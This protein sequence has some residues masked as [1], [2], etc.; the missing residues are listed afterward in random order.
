MRTRRPP[1]LAP[2]VSNCHDQANRHIYSVF[3]RNVVSVFHRPTV[4][5][6]YPSHAP[7]ILR[8]SARPSI[9]DRSLTL[10]PTEAVLVQFVTYLFQYPRDRAFLK[11]LV[12]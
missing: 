6:T 3:N 2:L 12:R 11:A 10:S 5:R 8:R 7:Q 1:S 4:M 9:G